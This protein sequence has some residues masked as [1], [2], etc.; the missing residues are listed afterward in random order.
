MKANKYLL[1]IKEIIADFDN[2]GENRYFIFGSSVRKEK[3]NDIDLAVV[4]LKKTGL[5]V[6]DLKERMD[7]STIPYF[8]DVVDFDSTSKSFQNYV[9]NNE[10]VVWIN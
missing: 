4:G 7:K 6:Y 9:L 2:S 8:V 5:K 10:P 3:F 1:K